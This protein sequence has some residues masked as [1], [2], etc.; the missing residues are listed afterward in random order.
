MYLDGI[1]LELIPSEVHAP[2]GSRIQ[3]TCKYTSP[4]QLEIVVIE[5]GRPA[6]R[7][8]DEYNILEKG[9]KKSWFSIVG[10]NPQVVQCM[11]RKMDY[12]VVGLI[13]SRVYPGLMKT[14]E[15][16]SVCSSYGGGGLVFSFQVHIL[17]L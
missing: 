8:D 4:E 12:T 5:H 9:A 15:A 2:P 14:V 7:S 1:S 11:V 3:F 13:S 17:H 10:P 6:F 16:A